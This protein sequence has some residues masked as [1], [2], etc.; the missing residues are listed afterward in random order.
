MQYS[1]PHVNEE[2]PPNKIHILLAQIRIHNALYKS[3]NFNIKI[4]SKT[5]ALF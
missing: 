5:F 1:Q 4:V 3:L 2:I